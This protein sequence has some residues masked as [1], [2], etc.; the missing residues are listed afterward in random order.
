MFFSELSPIQLMMFFSE[1]IISIT[2]MMMM[3]S[4]NSS[5]NTV[6]MIFFSEF[7]SQYSDVFSVNSSL[8]YSDDDVFQ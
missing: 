3:F 5:L 6:M 2:V 1:L 7:I 4:V 8:K